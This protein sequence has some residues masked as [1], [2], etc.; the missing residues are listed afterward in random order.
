M[1]KILVIDDSKMQANMLNAILEG[2]YAVTQAHTAEEGLNYAREGD[3]SLILLDVVMPGMDGFMLLKKLQEEVVTRQTPVILITSLSDIESEQCGLM[4]GAVDYIAKPF[5]PM[6]VKARVQTHIKLYKYRRQVEYQSMTD[7]LTGVA[8]RRRHDRYSAIR[9]QEAARLQI[10]FSVCMFDID[11]FKSY[12]DTF[13][14][15][16]GDKVITSV[17]QAAAAAPTMQTA[18][19]M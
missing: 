7:Q 18:R 9:W 12:N 3:F 8:N 16:A 2:D 14:H 1:D 5:H 4:L 15:P 11:H 13:G 10:P 6:I 17:A 19:A